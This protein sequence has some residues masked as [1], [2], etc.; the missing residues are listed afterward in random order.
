MNSSRYPVF[1]M[2]S[3]TNPRLPYH[4]HEQQQQQQ[5][6]QQ[7]FYFFGGPGTAPDAALV[8]Q[9]SSQYSNALD[10]N[11]LRAQLLKEKALREKAESELQQQKNVVADLTNKVQYAY[12]M[13][14]QM[15]ESYKLNNYKQVLMMENSRL[16]EKID[17]LEQ[18]NARLAK[19]L[20]STNEQDAAF[21][22][23][24]DLEGFDVNEMYGTKN[25]LL[26][27]ALNYDMTSRQSPEAFQNHS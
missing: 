26:L 22:Q 20:E 2:G 8:P 13:M 15:Q 3:I 1:V 17:Q 4:H 11:N 9:T 25:E 7:S 12:Y 27:M 23:K 6:P 5:L 24:E 19:Q 14:L 18:E 21:A 10:A 16:K